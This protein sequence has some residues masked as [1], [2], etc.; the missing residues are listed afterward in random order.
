ME[1]KTNSIMVDQALAEKYL[2][3]IG[4]SKNDITDYMVDER[5]GKVVFLHL[6]GHL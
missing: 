3:S 4:N 6:L 5:M 2:E 1:T